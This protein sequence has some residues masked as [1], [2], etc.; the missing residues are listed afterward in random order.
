VCG[1]EL[2]VIGTR[3]RKVIDKDGVEITLVLRRLRC[4]TC[5]KIHHELPDRVVPYKRHSAE[6][7]EEIVAGRADGVNCEESTVRRIKRWWE[8]YQLYFKSILASLR[9]KY[10]TEFSVSPTPKEIVR[11]VVNA[12]LW[13]H[14]RSAFLSG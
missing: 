9:E 2:R 4:G 14:T 3:K 11:A 12:N 6:T 13:V 1:G 8:A 7:I 5:R 10:E